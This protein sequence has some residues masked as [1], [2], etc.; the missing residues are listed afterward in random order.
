MELAFPW[1]L[2]GL[3]IL[4]PYLALRRRAWRSSALAYGPMQYRKPSMKGRLLV[5]LQLVL[6]VLLIGLLVLALCGPFREHKLEL[7][8]EEGLD[9]ALALDVSSSMMAADFPPNR[10]GALKKIASDFVK[11]SGSNRVGV[12]LFAKDTFTQTPLTSDHAILLELIDGISYTMIDHS[13]SGGTAI[14][15]ALL[16]AADN[17]LKARI[18]KRDQVIIL[19][20]DGE[21]NSGADPLLAARFVRDSSIRLYIIGV[22]GEEPAK[23][24][25]DG[26]PFITS[27]G[28]ELLTQLDDKQLKAIAQEGDGRYLRARSAGILSEIFGEL[29]RLETTPLRSESFRLRDYYTAQASAGAAALFML[30]LLLGMFLRRPFR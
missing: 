23:V 12:Y 18:E 24:L 3:L 2:L 15:D 26:K 9:V 8:E 21:S 13:V 7:V 28:T 20:T 29:A 6:E 1:G 14:G 17:L 5:S 19:V 11:R 16:Y 4:L 30:W 22:G 25:I 10:L 27:E